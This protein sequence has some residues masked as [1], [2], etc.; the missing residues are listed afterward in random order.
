M[1]KD[2]KVWAIKLRGRSFYKDSYDIPFIYPT[3]RHAM[4]EAENIAEWKNRNPNNRSPKT[5][6]IRVKVCIEEIT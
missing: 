1:N 4:Q 2:R 6:I 3:R 5:E